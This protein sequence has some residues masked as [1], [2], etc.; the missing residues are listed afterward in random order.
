MDNRQLD[1]SQHRAQAQKYPLCFLAHDINVPANIGSL[2]RLADALGV[3]MIYL[4]GTSPVPPSSTIRKTSRATEDVVPFAYAKNPLDAITQLK[5]QG[6]TIISLEITTASVDVRELSIPRDAQ[7]CLILGA[8]SAG[9]AQALLDVSDHTVHI[10]ML[11]RNSSMNVATAC[12]IATFEITRKL[13][14]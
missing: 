3:Q 9:V 7:V 12:A 8:E 2:F 1:H 6:Y 4:S 13:R 10:P 11:G 5:S 14:R